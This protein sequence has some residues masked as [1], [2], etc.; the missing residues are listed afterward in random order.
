MLH[1]NRRHLGPHDSGRLSTRARAY[2]A[3]GGIRAEFWVNPFRFLLILFLLH[4]VQTIA[5]E[6]KSPSDSKN[7]PFFHKPRQDQKFIYLQ[8]KSIVD[9][10][11]G[12]CFDLSNLTLEQEHSG[13]SKR[14]ELP[15]VA[16]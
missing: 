10:Y 2:F 9:A 11:A 7:K 13:L 15:S 16:G 6:K 12:H 4:H 8:K 5:V 14:W 3:L 1:Y